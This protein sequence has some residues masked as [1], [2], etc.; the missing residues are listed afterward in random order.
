MADKKKKKDGALVE[1]AEAVGS[2]VGKVAAAL[3]VKN[4][5]PTNIKIPKLAKS[6]KSRLPRKEKKANKKAVEAAA[7]K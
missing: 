3:G 7:R 6:G 5:P 2:A 4:T 1:A